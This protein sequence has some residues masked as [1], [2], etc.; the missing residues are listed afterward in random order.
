MHH[1]IR[2]WFEQHDGDDGDFNI[3]PRSYL[4][5]VVP[6]ANATDT[7]LYCTKPHTIRELLYALD[8]E[9]PR[10]E[11]PFAAVLRNGLPSEADASWLA[12]IADNPSANC[13]RPLR[14]RLIDA[15]SPESSEVTDLGYSSRLVFLGDAD[16]ADL[17]IFAWLRELVAIEYCGLSDALL[18]KCGVPFENRL[19]IDMKPSEIA[20]MPL[21]AEHLGDL[22]ALLGPWCAGLL[23]AGH[24]IELEALFSFATATPPQIATALVRCST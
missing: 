21:V 6:P 23:A 22:P 14:D 12:T 3:A 18:Q 24:K 17:L 7:V 16:P 20:A 2:D 8:E 5:D 11:L 10:D 4:F 13:S 15:N 19:T 9:R 1:P